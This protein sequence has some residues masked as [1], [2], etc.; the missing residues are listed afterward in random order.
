MRFSEAQAFRILLY[1]A[2]V[3]IVI[4]LIMVLVRTL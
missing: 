1:C 4:A 3:V 2:A